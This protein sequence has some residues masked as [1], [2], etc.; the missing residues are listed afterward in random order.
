MQGLWAGKAAQSKELAA[1]LRSFGAAGVLA[2]GLFNTVYYT[3]AFLFV[4][5]YVAPSPG[6]LGFTAAAK[7]FLRVFAMVWAG[8]QVTKAARAGGALLLAP[9]VERG[10]VLV[11][12]RFRFRSKGQAFGAVAGACFALA[13]ILFMTI[14]TLWA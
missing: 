5:L 10:L 1:K 8:S 4:W 6:G 9:A 13:A 11:T 14:T 3:G 7:R 12:E 2:Y